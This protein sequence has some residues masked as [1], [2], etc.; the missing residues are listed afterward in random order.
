[1]ETIIAI[2]I[3]S[4]IIIVVGIPFN[5]L[6]SKGINKKIVLITNGILIAITAGVIIYSTVDDQ[7][8]KKQTG[9]DN[10]A[11]TVWFTPVTLSYSE[12]IGDYYI[13]SQRG[14][15]FDTSLIAVSKGN[16]ELPDSI[17][18]DTKIRVAYKKMSGR[19]WYKDNTI[20]LGDRTYYYAESVTGIFPDYWEVRFNIVFYDIIAAV[21]FNLFELPIVIS[22]MIEQRRKR[23]ISENSAVG[24]KNNT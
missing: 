16:I 10:F 8:I 21:I 11:Q 22:W 24:T 2:L 17:S 3:L 9:A 20:T 6:R 13:L 14:L 15:M 23:N 18:T 7:I 12:T 5:C 4:G 19:S 1:M